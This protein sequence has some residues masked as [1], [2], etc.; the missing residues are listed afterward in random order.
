MESS[1][2][3]PRILSRSTSLPGQRLRASR[4]T[5]QSIMP[6]NIFLARVFEGPLQDLP[7]PPPGVR[8]CGTLVPASVQSQGYPAEPTPSS[9]LQSRPDRL[10]FPHTQNPNCPMHPQTRDS[11]P[12]LSYIEQSRRRS[13]VR[14][15]RFPPPSSQSAEKAGRAQTHAW[16]PLRPRGS[17]D[18]CPETSH[19]T[20]AR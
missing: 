3:V 2:S 13:D 15:R 8:P 18:G 14:T 5:R 11:V 4:T 1:L 20:G 17:D 19:T 6:S 9:M 16:P 7:S 12:A 10:A